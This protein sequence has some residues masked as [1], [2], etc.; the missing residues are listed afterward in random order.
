[1]QPRAGWWPLDAATGQVVAAGCGPV[2]PGDRATIM[3]R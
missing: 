2:R 1:M 3:I